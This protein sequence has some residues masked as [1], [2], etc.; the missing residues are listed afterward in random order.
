MKHDP[1]H[2]APVGTFLIGIEHP[3]IGDCVLLIVYG[4]GRISRCQIGDIWIKR[5]FFHGALLLY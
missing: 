3:E 1:R 2:L 4:Q 5:R